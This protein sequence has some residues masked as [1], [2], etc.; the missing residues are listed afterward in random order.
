MAIFN[1]NGINGIYAD[2]VNNSSLENLTD[3]VALQQNDS[4]NSTIN[5]NSTVNSTVLA[6][7][8]GYSDIH[9]MWV[10]TWEALE[11]NVTEL[12]NEG[13]TDIFVKNNTYSNSTYIT[14]LSQVV[15]MFKDSGIRVN[16]WIS[17]FMNANGTWVNPA[18]TTYT[19]TVKVT[20]KVPVKTKRYK[21]WYKKWYKYHGKW[22]YKWKYVWKTKTT[23]KTVTTTETK[24]GINTIYND[25]VVKSIEDM[26]K[27]SGVNGVNLDYVC[28]PGTAYK[29]SGSTQVIT[30][31]VKRIHDSVKSID[32][33]VS[34]SANLMPE[35]TMNAYYYG[36]NYTQLGQYLDFMVP[37]IYKGDYGYNSSNGTNSNNQNGTDW[38]GSTVAYIVSQAN[39]TPVVAGLQTYRSGNN[40]TQIPAAE[41]NED[42][43]AALNNGASGYSLN[44]FMT[45]GRPVY[46][47]SDNIIN[48][49]VDTNRINTIVYGLQNLGLTAI[50]W[51]LGSNSHYAVLQDSLVP[52]NALIVDIYGGACAGTIYEM[53]QS[54]YKR[55]VGTKEVF[56]VWMPPATDITGLAWLPRA[57]DD[58]FSPASFTGLEH[59]DQYLKNNGYNYIYS[60]D[61]NAIINAIYDEAITA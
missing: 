6:E 1:L 28:Y 10:N 17:C 35:G 42:I 53:G 22:R 14:I 47:T 9:G 48:T 61:L 46:I 36:Q 56:C 58:N 52:A 8:N 2:N 4:T 55:L 7:G 32:T 23:Y 12:Q 54:Y 11:L 50:N 30:S 49:A 21:S 39:G 16:A 13:I 44:I 60:G 57:H 41:L 18:G 19:Y 26:V 43:Q 27:N 38:I 29:Y 51:G 31:F 45:Q 24:T 15:N 33:E 5:N 3:D 34:I 59:P 20:K 37:M 40:L 25:Q